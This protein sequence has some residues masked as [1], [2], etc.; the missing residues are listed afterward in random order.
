[1]NIDLAKQFSPYP[2]GRF[3]T[4]GTHNGETFRDSVL[5]PALTRAKT[6]HGSE[7]VV[8]NIDGVRTFGS[9]FLEEAFAGLI[10]K[11]RFTRDELEQLLV[12]E[13]S[14]PHLMIFRDSISGYIKSAQ[15]EFDGV[16]HS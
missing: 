9:S 15:P 1:M 2:S 11:R 3:P 8:V 10:R 4:D 16:L 12:I 5:L 14:K 13:C 7:K 6:S